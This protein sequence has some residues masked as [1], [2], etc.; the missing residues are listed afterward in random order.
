MA[1]KGDDIRTSR[2]PNPSSSDGAHNR[3]SRSLRPFRFALPSFL[4][5]FKG[6]LLSSFPL[7]N[8]NPLHRNVILPAYLPFPRS[9][10]ARTKIKRSSVVKR[11]KKVVTSNPKTTAHVVPET[12]SSDEQKP[13]RRRLDA[14][15]YIKRRFLYEDD[16]QTKRVRN[17]SVSKHASD[18]ISRFRNSGSTAA[19][20]A[21]SSAN[22]MHK[23]R[24]KNADRVSHPTKT[25]TQLRNRRGRKPKPR[26]YDSRL[27]EGDSVNRSGLI[28]D[29]DNETE[30]HTSDDAQSPVP[31][32]HYRPGD[33]RHYERL[34]GDTNPLAPLFHNAKHP[35]YRNRELSLSPEEL[36]SQND[37]RFAPFSELV[38]DDNADGFSR[39]G[40]PQMPSKRLRH[41]LI[42][43]PTRKPEIP[44]SLSSY[45]GKGFDEFETPEKT[46]FHGHS[47]IRPIIPENVNELHN[48][49][50][51]PQIEQINLQVDDKDQL[52]S[53]HDPAV[54]D[55]DEFSGDLLHQRMAA[56]PAT[57]SSRRKSPIRPMQV[58]RT[59][60]LIY[61]DPVGERV[62]REARPYMV[63]SIH[64]RF[65]GSTSLIQQ[66]QP[67]LTSAMSQSDHSDGI[68]GDMRTFPD[69]IHTGL[70]DLCAA[71]HDELADLHSTT[72]GGYIS[73]SST[74]SSV[75]GIG[76]LGAPVTTVTKLPV[77]SMPQQLSVISPNVVS[78]HI[79]VDTSAPKIRP[80]TQTLGLP[81]KSAV[82][83]YT[84]Y[85]PHG[86]SKPQSNMN[87]PIS[88][89]K[90]AGSSRRRPTILKRTGISTSAVSASSTT[91]TKPIM[92]YTPTLTMTCPTGIPMVS[93]TS[94]TR[95]Q[96]PFMRSLNAITAGTGGL[97]KLPLGVGASVDSGLIMDSAAPT[98]G[99]LAGGQLVR[100]VTSTAGTVNAP[101]AY[102]VVTCSAPAA[103]TNQTASSRL[104]GRKLHTPESRQAVTILSGANVCLPGTTSVVPGQRMAAVR[105]TVIRGASD[106]KKY[107][108]LGGT[109]ARLMQQ[110]LGI[111]EMNM[112]LPQSDGQLPSETAEAVEAIQFPSWSVPM[113]TASDSPVIL[114]PTSP[115]NG[116]LPEPAVV[117]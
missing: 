20:M 34:A 15:D 45:P 44:K 100:L 96:P 80:G 106:G 48:T 38:F 41:H 76:D 23:K 89:L 117:S 103:P 6:Q 24:K 97:Q 43:K 98:A 92:S 55:V 19:L 108:L 116:Q 63:D 29:F 32:Y 58:V 7:S 2:K 107:V 66:Q 88:G 57:G 28:D 109:P 16:T 102:A 9:L 36:H 39:G 56:V 65:G 50:Q 72:E 13:R 30:D 1:K 33:F 74:A 81:V 53:P 99:S 31:G 71:A 87:S 104:F 86:Q 77:V 75:P 73:P 12:A 61:Q 17:K 49:P 5:S 8:R 84:G 90:A 26:S 93:P 18:V 27:S 25:P 54:V 22:L 85:S 4:I 105:Y 67:V 64:A 111:P 110:P 112:E 69:Q 21:V 60:P 91:Q 59:E 101:L 68:D 51:Q 37:Q 78:G 14:E 42:P 10:K 47:D 114:G 82:P 83:K 35:S 46:S 52:L 40:N 11:L 3:P 62:G 94:V 115:S 79:F 95:F 113:E 70:V